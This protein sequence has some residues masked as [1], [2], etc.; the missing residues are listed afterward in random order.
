MART[1]DH[2]AARTTENQLFLACKGP[3]SDHLRQ[4]AHDTT[5]PSLSEWLLRLGRCSNPALP[6][7]RLAAKRTG[8][9]DQHY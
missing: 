4:L 8:P 7:E 5:G 6:S 2:Q 3:V 1:D 9:H